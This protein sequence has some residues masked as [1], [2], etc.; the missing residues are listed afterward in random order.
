VSLIARLE[1]SLRTRPGE[2]A[3]LDGDPARAAVMIA[4]R[5]DRGEPELLLI[6]R[7]EREGDP[8]SGQIALP[9]GR[10]SPN[11]LSLEHT[12]VRETREETGLDVHATGRVIGVLDELRPRTP[13]LPPI[14]VTPYVAVVDPPDPLQFNHEVAE[15]FWVPWPVLAD[16]AS[17]RESEVQVRGATW[18]APSFVIHEYIVWGMTERILRGLL[19][20]VP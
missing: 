3:A 18:R 15:A 9:G 12:A 20:R 1:E 10:R 4:F 14:V 17:S 13:V 5:V 2:P 16:P 8:W 11:D 6:R 19:A 7:A